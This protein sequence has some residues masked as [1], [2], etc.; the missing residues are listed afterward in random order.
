[1][2]KRCMEEFEVDPK[3]FPPRAVRARISGAKNR[4]LDAE[5]YR[6]D[7]GLVFEETVA[8]V[9]ALYE[10]RMLEAN[11]MDFDDLLVAPSTC[12]S[13]TRTSA[14]ATGAP[15]AGSSSTSTRT[16][17]AP[18]TGSCSCYAST[19]NLTVVG[20][21]SQCLLAGTQVLMANRSTSRSSEV[22]EG[23]A[24]CPLVGAVTSEPP[25]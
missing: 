21:E 24:F 7:A 20:D 13:S 4:L 6:E 15:S 3:R 1:M 2:V 14:T 18:S 23:D 5:A 16:R 25:R 12:W 17:T 22:Q 9:Y 10:K 19:R 11:A 8:D